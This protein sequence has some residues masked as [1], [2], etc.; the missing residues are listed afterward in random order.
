MNVCGKLFVSLFM[1]LHF[2]IVKNFM[3]NNNDNNNYYKFQTNAKP[4]RKVI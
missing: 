1:H 2:V 3:K 4:I